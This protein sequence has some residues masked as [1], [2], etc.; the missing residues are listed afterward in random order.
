MANLPAP[1]L[2]NLFTKPLNSGEGMVRE[3]GSNFWMDVKSQK[4]AK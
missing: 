4:R 1:D 2:I 3:W